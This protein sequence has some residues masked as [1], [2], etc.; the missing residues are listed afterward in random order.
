LVSEKGVS[1]E[2]EFASALR[3]SLHDVFLAVFSGQ[4]KR[5]F[6]T[7]L[8]CKRAFVAIILTVPIGFLGTTLRVRSG[9]R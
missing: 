7:H 1:D 2:A 9:A 5:Q 8:P 6:I 3:A 4:E